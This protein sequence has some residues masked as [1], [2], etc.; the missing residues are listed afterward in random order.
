MISDILKLLPKRLTFL[1]QNK[2]PKI[3]LLMLRNLN[4]IM[5]SKTINS[6]TERLFESSNNLHSRNASIIIHSSANYSALFSK[7]QSSFH[8]I[9]ADPLYKFPI[10][11]IEKPSR[12][13]LNFSSFTSA[14][15]VNLK[16]TF[17]QFHQRSPFQRNR[18]F[19]G[20]NS[21]TSSYL[22]SYK[23]TLELTNSYLKHNRAEESFKRQ[24]VISSDS[25]IA[26][27]FLMNLNLD[28]GLS[29]STVRSDEV[30]FS[31]DMEEMS[32]I[33]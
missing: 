23:N 13:L 17:K 1:F 15:T 27:T 16:Q 26:Q 32:N 2:N 33:E 4:N 9:F 21:D 24:S 19:K 18:S 10:L 30:V 22:S 20:V 5:E 25:S 8:G 3:L 12:A 7:Q 14:E 28:T 6:H 11:T 29:F 31:P